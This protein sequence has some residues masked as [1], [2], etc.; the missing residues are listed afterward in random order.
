VPEQVGGRAARDQ[1][2]VQ[3]RLDL[4]LQPRALAHDVR[5][6]RDLATKRVRVIVGQPHRRQVIRREQLR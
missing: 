6:P 1:V 3:D 5:A 4:V 2:A